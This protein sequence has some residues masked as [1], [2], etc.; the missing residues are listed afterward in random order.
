MICQKHCEKLWGIHWK[1]MGFF[2]FNSEILSLSGT[3]KT[4][5]GATQNVIK[6]ELARLSLCP[7]AFPRGPAW[8]RDG[9][10][11]LGPPKRPQLHPWATNR[12]CKLVGEELEKVALVPSPRLLWRR[13]GHPIFHKERGGR[14]GIPRSADL[15]QPA[16]ELGQGFPHLQV[17]TDTHHS[18]RR[19]RD[20]DSW[21]RES[22]PPGGW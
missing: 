20:K 18:L 7:W 3:I 21:K 2:S 1:Q 9:A 6:Q 5:R 11:G 13:P 19:A 22:G 15:F 16:P 8:G 14:R 12:F 17:S 4:N 10:V